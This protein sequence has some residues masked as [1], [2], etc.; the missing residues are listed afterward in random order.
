MCG[1]GS[2]ARGSGRDVGE[3]SRRFPE[4][5]DSGGV[6]SRRKGCLLLRRA[7]EWHRQAPTTEKSMGAPAPPAGAPPAQNLGNRNG[8]SHGPG[9]I[10]GVKR[11]SIRFL[12]AVLFGWYLI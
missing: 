7:R 1:L 8:C 12:L 6:R 4:H 2:S 9:I 11:R 3:P 10:E 5:H